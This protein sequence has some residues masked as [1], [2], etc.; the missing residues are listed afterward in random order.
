MN[1]ISALDNPKGVDMP[2]NKSDQTNSISFY[3]YKF[4][5]INNVC[6]DSWPR[7]N[8]PFPT[9]SWVFIVNSYFV[10]YACLKSSL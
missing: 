2:L 3:I 7:T 4:Y 5:S 10:R 6:I 8:S 1:Q 9:F